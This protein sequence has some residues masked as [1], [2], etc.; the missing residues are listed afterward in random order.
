MWP[1][2]VHFRI[3]CEVKAES[4]FNSL[5]RSLNPNIFFIGVNKILNQDSELFFEP[6]SID[7]RAK[8]FLQI[9]QSAEQEL[10]RHFRSKMMYSGAGIQ[11]EMDIRLSRESYRL[12]IE[13]I[14][15]KS[16]GS[17]Q[18]RYFVADGVVVNK[19]IVY[20]ILTLAREV[21]ESHDH[22]KVKLHDE[23]L[24]I[25]TSLL[26][27][28]VNAY[29]KDCMLGLSLPEPGRNL[30]EDTR[31]A[32]EILRAAAR[33]F[34]YTI[35]CK[36]QKFEGLHGLF[37]TC[38]SIS[39]YRYEGKENIGQLFI[40]ASDH[41]SVHYDLELKVSFRLRDHRK[42]RKLLQLTDGDIGMISN[43]F[44]VTGLGKIKS[45]YDPTSESIFKIV[46]TG[47]HCWEVW[48]ANKCILV[49]RYGM[50][51]L[52]SEAIEKHQFFTDC[53]RIFQNA[54]EDIIANLY[55]LASAATRQKNG[56]MLIVTEDAELEAKR[57][58]KQC[59]E[60][61]PQKIDAHMLLNLSTIDG[62][63]LIN[64]KG[65]VFAHGV[66][67]DGV[68]S[69]HGDSARGSRY[70]SAITYHDYRGRSKPT[71]IIVVSEDGAVDTIPTL[72][73]QIKRTEIDDMIS[74]LNG[75][76]D[77]FN[78][79]TFNQVMSWFRSRQ[80]YL[81]EDDCVIIN[82]LRSEIDE[83]NPTD[84]RVVYDDF[85]VDPEMDDTYYLL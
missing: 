49:M 71:L 30:S 82:K 6:E 52:P 41:A 44:E 29:L 17:H 73:P 67:L 28:T 81:L 60:V 20:V 51:Y 59:I 46:F 11:Q 61:A 35:S 69:D 25:E 40:C 3:S 33:H 7:A 62:G 72:R 75:L 68:V 21:Y 32:E 18:N 16:E 45:N 4:V 14:L 27:A 70:N 24:S 76:K 80:F 15:N 37:D 34:M 19:H 9:H 78:R 56:A 5:D 26:D 48:H 63:V 2:Q 31:T 1:F 77:E 57:L 53:K 38:N 12:A 13:N 66:I 74:A 85:T 83:S 58:S 79:T 23:L 54:Q 39:T 64:P 42:T 47:I 84:L 65:V 55:H 8:D 22:L 43:T 10:R 50:P 36:G